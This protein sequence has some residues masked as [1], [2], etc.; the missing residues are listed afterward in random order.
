MLQVVSGLNYLHENNLMHRD[1][2]PE[3]IFVTKEN[4]EYCL[5]IGDFGL[6]TEASEDEDHKTVCGTLNFMSPEVA[7]SK[8]YNFPSD[9]FSL[10]VVFY[11]MMSFKV[12][13][14]WLIIKVENLVFRFAFESK[15]YNYGNKI[16][17]GSC[18]IL[19]YSSFQGL[20]T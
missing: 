7:S 3:N 12:I 6:A 16:R 13:S 2:K 8:P 10:G 5:K 19:F 18:N 14:Y 11:S 15:K 1:I 20:F 9:I 17:Y 4:D